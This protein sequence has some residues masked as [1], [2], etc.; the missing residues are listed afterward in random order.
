[1]KRLMIA[2]SH[3]GHWAE[4]LRALPAFPLNSPD[5]EFIFVCTEPEHPPHTAGGSSTVV[6][7]DCNAG[8][9]VRLLKCI[10]ACGASV[11][12]TKP[13]LIFS[14]GAAPGLIAI[15][16]GRLCGAHTIWLDSIANTEQLS[17]SGKLA[18][19]L[20]HQCFTQWEHLTDSRTSYLG[21]V[22]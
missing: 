21:T 15:A 5:H 8:T 7:P 17:L 20:A 4:A 13:A 1:M 22:L 19:Y 16:W 6:V 10:L 14:T 11:R 9:P 3:G 12:R 2:A 18:R